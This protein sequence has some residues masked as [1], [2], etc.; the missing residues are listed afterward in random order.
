M[1]L[2]LF[3]LFCRVYKERSFSRAAREL[4]LTQP[5]I[6]THI[7]ELEDALGTQLFN[8]AGREI[9]PTE[10]GHFLYEHAKSLLTLRRSLIEK[11]AVFL[12]RVEGVLTVGASSVPGEYLLP[13]LMTGFHAQHPGV[14]ARLRITDTAETIDDIRHGEVEL[15]VVGGTLPD[16]DLVFE[17]LA[18]DTLVLIVPTTQEWKNR[19]HFTLRELRRIPLLVREAG[20]GNRT[21]LERALAPRKMTLADF[22]IAAELGSMGAIKQAVKEGHGVSFVSEL[23]IASER[24]AGDIQVARVRELGQIRRTYH[25]AFSRRRVLSPVTQAFLEYLRRSSGGARVAARHAG[26]RKAKTKTS[27]R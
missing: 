11:M 24:R 5:T 9:Q 13:A 12:K 21:D 14:C 7:K 10:A 25:T 15:G 6:S 2:R 17:P 18:S 4:S 20:S 22:D 3:E 27:Q 26:R 23:A 16:D 8:R 1:D 19:T